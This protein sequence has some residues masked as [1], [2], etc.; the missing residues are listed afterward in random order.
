M[1]I[2]NVNFGADGIALSADGSTLYFSTTGGRRLYA[3]P[4][5]RLRDRSPNSE[6]LARASQVYLTGK[7]L[8]DGMETDSNNNIYMGNIE[9]NS[10]S[11]YTPSTGLLST[12]VRDPRLS[13]TDTLSTGADG[14]L[15][16]TENQLWRLPAYNGGVDKRVKPYVLFRAPLP[17]NGTKVTQP[18]P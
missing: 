4:T 7:G 11:M 17:G 6:V 2:S 15:Y 14:Y 5:D 3:V 12:F 9:T 16:F 10:I 13:W 18:A 8:T 1:F